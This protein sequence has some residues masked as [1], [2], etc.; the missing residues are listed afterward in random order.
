MSATCR[1]IEVKKPGELAEVR[2]PV[3][4]LGSN[5]VERAFY[6][7]ENITLPSPSIVVGA[8]SVN[9]E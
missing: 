6:H 2:K 7:H 4:A 8:R 1:A 9:R 3:Q 5:Q